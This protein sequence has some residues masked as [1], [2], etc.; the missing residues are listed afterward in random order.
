MQ[1]RIEHKDGRAY[2]V[3]LDAFTQLYEPFGFTITGIVYAGAMLPDTPDNRALATDHPI[4]DVNVSPEAQA[5][6]DIGNAGYVNPD[7]V[8]HLVN[9]DGSAFDPATLDNENPDH[10]AVMT[11]EPNTATVPVSSLPNVQPNTPVS[12]ATPNPLANQVAFVEDK[13]A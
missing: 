5:F 7:N 6:I 9:E 1:V 8:G 2:Q 11:N 12:P 10:P 4:E 13:K 3:S